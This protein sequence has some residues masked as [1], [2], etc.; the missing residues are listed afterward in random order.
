MEIMRK[1]LLDSEPLV[2]IRELA[3]DIGLNESIVLQQIHY[4]LR[5]NKKS[6]SNMRNGHYWVYNTYEEWQ[7]EFPFWSVATIKRIITKLE[8]E[9]WLISDNFNKLKIDRTKWYRINYEKLE[10]FENPPKYQNDPMDR[11]TCTDGLGQIDPTI[12]RDYPENTSDTNILF[13]EPLEDKPED[14]HKE[15]LFTLW[16]SQNIIVHGELTPEMAKALDKALKKWDEDTIAEAIRRYGK[17]YHDA[18]YFFDYK[19]SLANFLTQKNTL[20]DF[21][22]EG[23]KWQNYLTSQKKVSPKTKPKED[24]PYDEDDWGFKKI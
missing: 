17:V 23:Q 10:P 11:S 18:N 2:I 13:P 22:D 14:G 5:I 3:I 9:G 7:K 16:N 24:D 20:P 19:W 12:T 15:R 6:K 8:R 21:L 1:L 4:W